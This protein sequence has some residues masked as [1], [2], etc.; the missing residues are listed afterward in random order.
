VVAVI[1]GAEL[2][3]V[4]PEVAKAGF[5]G[6]AC[7]NDLSAR[8][9]QMATER[10]TLGKNADS[11]GPLGPW[12]VTADEI[13]D[14]DGLRIQTRV[15]GTIVQDDNTSNLIFSGA[16]IAAYA[17]GAMTLK[18]GDLIATGTPQ[19]VGVARKP[20]MFLHNGDLVEVEIERIGR[21]ANR[22]VQR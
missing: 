14:P 22:I 3:D 20:P 9:F 2:R 10:W 19:G 13:Q 7:F 16:K 18:P 11:S 12:I 17:S 6:Y 21:I 5:L 15:N 4:T 1:V 8:K